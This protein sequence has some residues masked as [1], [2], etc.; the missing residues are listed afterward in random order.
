MR[1]M[2]TGAAGF[3]GGVLAKYCLDA[4]HSVLGV[5][6]SSPQEAWR[7]GSFEMCGVRDT[8]RMYDLLAPFQPDRIVHLA[9]QSYPTVSLE[10]PQETMDIN[11]GGTICLFETL[12]RL[13]MAP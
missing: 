2:I 7:D 5:G 12:R 11:V 9:A 8:A 1:V 6:V 3:I 10:R 13:D 4:G